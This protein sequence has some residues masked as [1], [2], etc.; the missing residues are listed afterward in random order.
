MVPTEAICNLQNGPDV[1]EMETEDS[2]MTH[3]FSFNTFSCHVHD[4]GSFDM[5]ALSCLSHLEL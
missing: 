4:R 3:R 5:L 2:L 1:G